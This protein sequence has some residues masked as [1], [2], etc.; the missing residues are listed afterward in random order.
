MLHPSSSARSQGFETTENDWEAGS[1]VADEEDT[2]PALTG[3]QSK[4]INRR[5][6]QKADQL[7]RGRMRK[8]KK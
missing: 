3:G 1:E 7:P 6:Q 2:D 4:R 5:L 8:K